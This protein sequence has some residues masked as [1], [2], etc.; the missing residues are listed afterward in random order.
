MKKLK[1]LAHKRPKWKMMIMSVI[2]LDKPK[3]KQ[4]NGKV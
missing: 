4:I 1:S 2:R 3:E